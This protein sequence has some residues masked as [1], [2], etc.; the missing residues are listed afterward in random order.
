MSES[1]KDSESRSSRK[2]ICFIFGSSEIK[3]PG[4]IRRYSH[5]YKDSGD[6][7]VLSADGG[8]KNTCLAG[9][10]PDLVIGDQDSGGIAGD[11]HASILLPTQKDI[12]DVHACIDYA[13]ETACG[14]L[15]LLGCTGGRLDHFFGNVFLL[16]Y[17]RDKGA[18]GILADENNEIRLLS[19]GTE[20]FVPEEWYQYV[21]LLPLDKELTGVTLQN[22]KYPLQNA[23]LRRSYPIGVSNEPAGGRFSVTIRTGRALLVFSRDPKG[24]RV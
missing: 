20:E 7:L 21:S 14:Q 12:T 22:L 24:E 4:Y 18:Q 1:T 16:E 6:I 2:S 11:K 19:G 9:F 23:V 10:T 15:L 3:D 8:L 5:R 17:I 13:L